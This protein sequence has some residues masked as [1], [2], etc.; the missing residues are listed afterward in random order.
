[1]G[2]ELSC[3]SSHAFCKL[4]GLRGTLAITLQLSHHYTL[5]HCTASVH[6]LPEPGYIQSNYTVI[7]I[8]SSLS[9]LAFQRWEFFH[10]TF[11]MVYRLETFFLINQQSLL[12]FL[13]L[14]RR[15]KKIRPWA[16]SER[17]ISLFE[18]LFL[19]NRHKVLIFLFGPWPQ[20][21]FYLF[22]PS[23]YLLRSNRSAFRAPEAMLLP[24]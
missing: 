4:L 15:E 6:S 17:K 18:S 1:M 10:V 23:L 7:S 16:D 24:S 2:G 12:F 3:L 11:T 20:T 21:V 8:F 22:P 13:L 19:P 9:L 14:K 5:V